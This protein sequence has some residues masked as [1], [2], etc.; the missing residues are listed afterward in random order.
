MGRRWIKMRTSDTVTEIAK[1]LSKTQAELKNPSKNK[2]VSV[3]TQAGGTYSYK[4]ADLAD[5]LDQ[6]KPVLSKNGLTIIQGNSDVTN[7]VNIITLLLHESGEWISTDL[8]MP[9][10]H[11]TRMNPAQALGSILTYGR[12]YAIT[13]LLNLAS[14][15]D[16]DAN[17]PEAPKPTASSVSANEGITRKC[18]S[19]G[20]V[21]R[22]HKPGCPTGGVVP[23]PSQS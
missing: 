19:C 10:A 7:G 18:D 15:E 5:I 20:A 13:S 16:D 22:F 23:S 12:R 2:T 8:L 6:V 9:P 1:A 17:A 11:E 14:D 4:Y 21:G 3:R